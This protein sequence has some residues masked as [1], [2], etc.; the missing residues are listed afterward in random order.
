M[1]WIA[2]WIDW[3]DFELN[4]KN[5]KKNKDQSRVKFGQIKF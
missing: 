3:Y 4:Y 2:K 5:I 1:I